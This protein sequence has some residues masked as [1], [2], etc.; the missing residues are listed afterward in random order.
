MGEVNLSLNRPIPLVPNT[1]L[2]QVWC[3]RNLALLLGNVPNFLLLKDPHD[4]CQSNGPW[5]G[6]RHPVIVGDFVI[7]S[8]QTKFLELWAIWLS[9]QCFTILLECPE[10][11]IQSDMP[12]LWHTSSIR[13]DPKVA[14]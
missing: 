7:V 11:W 9:L 6:L 12:H 2:S 10:I 14:L 5:R 1:R 8:L 13:K 3:C 4:R